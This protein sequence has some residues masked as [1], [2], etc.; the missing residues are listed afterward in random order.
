M[1]RLEDLDALMQY[2]SGGELNLEATTDF[3]LSSTS[4]TKLGRGRAVTEAGNVAGLLNNE[5]YSGDDLD[6][7]G[8]VGTDFQT[9]S[10]SDHGY[11][12][13]NHLWK[14]VPAFSST[15]V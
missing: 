6:L 1:R 7:V 2:V 12:L 4:D 3:G 9:H 10:T 11:S 13:H 5:V 8:I 15:M 14:I